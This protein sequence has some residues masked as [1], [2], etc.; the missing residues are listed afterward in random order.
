MRLLYRTHFWPHW[1]KKILGSAG[2]ITAPYFPEPVLSPVLV[3]EG[4][5]EVANSPQSPKARVSAV[6]SVADII[7]G[8]AC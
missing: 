8:F 7:V 3:L 1:P 4:T 2:N 5:D 6:L